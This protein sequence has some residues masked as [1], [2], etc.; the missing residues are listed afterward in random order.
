MSDNGIYR[1]APTTPSLLNIVIFE[2][3]MAIFETKMVKLGENTIILAKTLSNW[4]QFQ[5]YL[6]QILSY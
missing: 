3:N 6:R 4:G 1:T 2:T 5:S